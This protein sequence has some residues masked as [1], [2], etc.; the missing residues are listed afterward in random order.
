MKDALHH[1]FLSI[2]LCGR[3]LLPI[4]LV[5]GFFQVVVIQPPLDNFLEMIIGTTFVV[6][7]LA[8][9]LIGL[10]MGLFPVGLA[11]VVGVLRILRG[12]PIHLMIAGVVMC[13]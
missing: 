1:F 7:G 4:I 5:I 6:L 10:E 8:F 12:W 11:I 9:F 2:L 13:W 3:D